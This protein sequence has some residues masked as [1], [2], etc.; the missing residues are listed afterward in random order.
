M[1]QSFP[2]DEVNGL[3]FGESQAYNFDSI[4]RG[5]PCATRFALEAGSSLPQKILSA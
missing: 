5:I 4:R 1:N 3:I 2:M